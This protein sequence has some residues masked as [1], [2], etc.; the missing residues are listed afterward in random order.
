MLVVTEVQPD[1]QFAEIAKPRDI[2][3]SVIING[4][5]NSKWKSLGEVLALI[6]NNNDE[7][8]TFVLVRH[9]REQEALS[10]NSKS[11]PQETSTC[12]DTDLTSSIN[13]DIKE[14]V[15]INLCEKYYGFGM[16]G[17][18]DYHKFTCFL[19]SCILVLVLTFNVYYIKIDHFT[20]PCPRQKLG[21][22]HKGAV[23]DE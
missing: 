19:G 3:L 21:P 11:S 12:Q 17:K 20:F 13:I 8:K 2:I 4:H 6:Q 10:S 18:D 14:R 5:K 15:S 16:T 7:K 9:S 1:S 22:S 23:R